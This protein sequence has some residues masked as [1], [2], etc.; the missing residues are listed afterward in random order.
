MGH[1]S[2]GQLSLSRN[3]D[4]LLSNTYRSNRMWETLESRRMMS[5]STTTTQEPVITPTTTT[6]L[7]DSPDKAAADLL[8]TLSDVVN[9]VIKGLGDSLE[10]IRRNL[11]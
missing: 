4:I 1:A 5:V 10:K 8:G 9:D 7:E 11:Q 3:A 2:S 6:A